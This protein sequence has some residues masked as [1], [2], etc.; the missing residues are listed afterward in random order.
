MT[1]LSQLRVNESPLP[2]PS[3]RCGIASAATAELLCCTVRLVG[4]FGA[5][6]RGHRQPHRPHDGDRVDG[7]PERNTVERADD[8]E[9][10]TV[11]GR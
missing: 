5:S 8:T 7:V 3:L 11:D 10:R 2:P 1:Q 6:A 9:G 4:D